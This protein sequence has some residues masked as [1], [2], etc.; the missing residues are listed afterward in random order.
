MLVENGGLVRAFPHSL[1]ESLLAGKP[2]LLSNTISMADYVR[3]SECGVVLPAMNV[4][5]LTSTIE[6]LVRNYGL[7]ARNAAQ[8]GPEEF[9]I[10]ALV[11]SYRRL[12][13][14]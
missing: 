13:A 11:E 6:T 14:S 3:S 2:V 1:I 4:H 8:V 7:F 10:T 9:S 12:Y 5:A